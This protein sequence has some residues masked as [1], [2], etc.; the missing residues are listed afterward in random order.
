MCHLVWF[1]PKFISSETKPQWKVKH[2]AIWDNRCTFLKKPLYLLIQTEMLINALSACKYFVILCGLQYSFQIS[3][4]DGLTCLVFRDH[5]PHPFLEMTLSFV[6][7]CYELKSPLM[8]F[9]LSQS[10]FCCTL[11]SELQEKQESLVNCPIVF[12]ANC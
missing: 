1:H 6:R 5:L 12:K 4:F 9:L 10:S 11:L 7:C 3:V 2:G 8:N